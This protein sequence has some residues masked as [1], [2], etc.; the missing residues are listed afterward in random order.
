MGTDGKSVEA[1]SAATS[2]LSNHNTSAQAGTLY[3]V[4]TPIGNL[5]DFTPRARDV[6][7]SVTAIAAEDTRHS[8]KLLQAYGIQTPLFALH[9]H[10]EADKA[11]GVIARLQAGDSIALISDAGTPLISDP[12]FPLIRLAQESGIT[13]CPIPG[14]S[15]LITALSVAGIATNRFCFEGF[16]PAKPGNR[17]NQLSA[18][19][20]EQR[21]LVFYE[22][23]HRIGAM[24]ADLVAIFGDTRQACVARELTKRF[25]ELAHG[26]LADLQQQFADAGRCRGEFVVV[27]AGCD[28]GHDQDSQEIATSTLLAALCAHLPVK[29]AAKITAELTGAAR[30]EL[31]Q[32]ALT[33][34]ASTDNS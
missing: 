19:C 18:L 23:P 15:A 31:Y 8:K 14:A 26:N 10:N 20:T 5:G 7:N 13:L 2:A 1:V 11:A 32:Q 34:R 25:E 24:L 27:V 16:L 4:A 17:R 30:N 9:E 3:V 28:E 33:L 12:G 6:L 21:T 22:A 29:T